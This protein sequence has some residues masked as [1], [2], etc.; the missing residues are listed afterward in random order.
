MKAMSHR[1]GG[2][3]FERLKAIGM[4]ALEGFEALVQFREMLVSIN[5]P[6]YNAHKRIKQKSHAEWHTK[7]LT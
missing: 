3:E 4:V 1:G 5:E 7:A 6:R 2:D